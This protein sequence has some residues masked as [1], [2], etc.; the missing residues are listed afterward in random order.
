ML[1]Q[2]F[3][4]A[5]VL[6]AKGGCP[7]EGGPLLQGASDL[8]LIAGGPRGAPQNPNSLLPL[9][10]RTAAAAAVEVLGSVT[11]VRLDIGVSLRV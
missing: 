6:A 2:V 11:R 10:L 3:D 4:C 9:V 8:F 1:G 5:A 7:Q